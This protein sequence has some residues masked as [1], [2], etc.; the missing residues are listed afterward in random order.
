MQKQD[1]IKLKLI[2]LGY[3]KKDYNRK[4]LMNWLDEKNKIIFIANPELINP[5]VFIQFNYDFLIPRVTNYKDYL[6]IK[7][8]YGG[9][10][11]TLEEKYLNYLKWLKSIKFFDF[12]NQNNINLNT[13]EKYWIIFSHNYK[14]IKK[15]NSESKESIKKSIK[16]KKIK[17]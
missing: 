2:R 8:K 16:I 15:I 12:V 10:P 1:L 13:F 5:N 7:K 17:I 11:I 4:G 6:K 9:L 14:A 3:S